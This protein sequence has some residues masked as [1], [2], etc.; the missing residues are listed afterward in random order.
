MILNSSR[1]IFVLLLLLAVVVMTIWWVFGGKQ[2]E[3]LPP[4]FGWHA[5]QKNEIPSAISGTASDSFKTPPNVRPLAIGTARNESGSGSR[6]SEAR[7]FNESARSLLRSAEIAK[8]DYALLRL[9]TR[10]IAFPAVGIP[11]R[12]FGQGGC[13]SFR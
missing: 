1:K 12:L 5:S 10:C 11:L 9:K 13:R 3:S 7:L 2:G 4:W 8:V 6:Y